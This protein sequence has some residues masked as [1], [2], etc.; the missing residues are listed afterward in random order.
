[1]IT[2]KVQS[3]AGRNKEERKFNES[4]LVSQPLLAAS[5]MVCAAVNRVLAADGEPPHSESAQTKSQLT[6]PDAPPGLANDWLRGQFNSFSNWDLGGQFRARYEHAEY[7]GAVDFSATGGH[8]SDN[9][10]LLRTFVHVG[11]D[12]TPW[13][14][15]YAEGRD[16]RGYWDE[17]NP[18]PDLDT[19]DLHQA[20]VQIGKPQLFPIIAKIGR[21]EL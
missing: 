18:N 2:L 9:R 5:I 8:S 20:F 1:M 14:N 12:P 19:A 10:M 3:I 16:S 17:R 13:L 4:K 11:Y 6:A 7:L 21:Q 15:F